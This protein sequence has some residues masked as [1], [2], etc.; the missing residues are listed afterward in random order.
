MKAGDDR[1]LGRGKQSEKEL[2]DLL[3]TEGPQ[4]AVS[5]GRVAWCAAGSGGGRKLK[6][7]NQALPPRP[8][9]A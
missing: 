1:E 2:W 5:E 3:G 4:Q 8:P 6:A 7:G 9:A